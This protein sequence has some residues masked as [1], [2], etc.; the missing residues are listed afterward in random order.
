MQVDCDKINFMWQ[1]ISFHKNVS[2]FEQD[3]D[4]EEAAKAADV[5]RKLA[6]ALRRRPVPLVIS[7]EAGQNFSPTTSPQLNSLRQAV[8]DMTNAVSV[9]AGQL[10]LPPAPPGGA[11]F[12]SA[13]QQLR[14]AADFRQL[15]AAIGPG[16]DPF[17]QLL[18][19][20]PP[21]TPSDDGRD[22]ESAWTSFGCGLCGLQPLNP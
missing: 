22:V 11:H 13:Q 3:P 1:N 8:A 12:P 15:V 6:A 16:W 19:P 2:R 21:Q 18:G 7:S 20:A 9:A 14:S 17:A 10:T 5:A 4:D